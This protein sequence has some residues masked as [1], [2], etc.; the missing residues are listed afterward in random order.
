M[1]NNLRSHIYKIR[2]TPLLGL[3]LLWP[4]LIIGLFIA[5]YSVAAWSTEQKI[6]GYFQTIALVMPCLITLLCTYI[7]QQEQRA[8]DCFNILCV[9]RS[10][11]RTFFSIFILLFVL[12]AI[13]VILSVAGFYFLWGQM[14]VA[15]Y[16]LSCIL[17]LIPIACLLFI[18]LFIA[19]RFGSSWCVAL[20]AIFL[21]LGAL[22]VTGLLDQL[23]YYLPSVWAPR[24]ATLMI[25]NF[26]HSD[27]IIK[28]AAE[29]RHGLFFCLVFTLILVVLIPSWFH[30]WDGRPSIGDE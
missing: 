22:G 7:A 19:L 4:F 8:G 24:F 21:L 20:G 18:Q 15:A 2:K 9:G 14:H 17:V 26:F 30:K 10:R 29:L 1:F 25:S 28:V 3:A 5:Y 11:L 23:W 27:N 16:V 6:T 12:V 13:G